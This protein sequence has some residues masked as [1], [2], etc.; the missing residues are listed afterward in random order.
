VLSRCFCVAI[1]VCNRIQFHSTCDWRLYLTVLE[2]HRLQ[3][4]GHLSLEDTNHRELWKNGN[5]PWFN[6]NAGYHQSQYHLNVSHH[7]LD[8]YFCKTTHL[9]ITWLF[10]FWYSLSDLESPMSWEFNIGWLWRIEMFV[11]HGNTYKPTRVDVPLRLQLLKHETN[12]CTKW[13]TCGAS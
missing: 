6:L 9:N 11:L 13:R 1:D 10:T 5:I 7:I 3:K 4:I 2:P 8:W 12:C